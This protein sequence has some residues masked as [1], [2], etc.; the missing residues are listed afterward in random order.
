MSNFATRFSNL[1][2]GRSPLC[3]G[4]DP[5]FDALAAWRL[6]ADPNGLRTFCDLVLDSTDSLVS[7]I[8]PQ[9]AFFEQFGPEGVVELVRVVARIKEQGALSLIDCK[10]GD[11]GSTL[12]AYAQTYIG[13][14]SPFDADS[15][16]VSPY[17]GVGALR[18]VFDRAAS[19]GGRARVFVVVRSSNSEGAQI[20][21][22]LLPD[23]R[24]VAD[25]IADEITELNQM[26]GG[27]IGPIGAV[28]G[29]TVQGAAA[30]TIERLPR[31]LLLAPGIGAQGATFDSMAISFGKAV[32][33]AIP[34]IS[35]G[36]LSA[37]PSVDNLKAAI[38]K[39]AI[40]H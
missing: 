29:A 2:M 25:A 15:I 18:P 36:I 5:S 14:G 26:Y 3:V 17:L 16:T 28:I 21:N 1:S 35:R 39:I 19:S 9:S 38:L 37:G 12:D 7:V 11:I 22:A 34:S 23:G 24:S 13:K 8:K 6:P 33:R 31:S 40:W 10:R 20:Q 30:K 27:E 4:L 32:L